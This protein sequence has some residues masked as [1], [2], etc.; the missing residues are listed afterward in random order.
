MKRILLICFV[1]M[2]C[3]V[4]SHAEENML[5]SYQSF[6]D[7]IS[8]GQVKYVTIGDFDMK[9]IKV[10]IIK[11]GKENIYLVDRPYKA[12]EDPLLISLLKEKSIPFEILESDHSRPGERLGVKGERLGVKS[13][14]LT[15]RMRPLQRHIDLGCFQNSE[16]DQ[17]ESSLTHHQSTS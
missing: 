17:I 16:Q 12:G 15:F 5:L 13:L 3:S 8:S 2:A 1:I 14:F 6:I 10:T 7:Y 4:L 11:D 9:D